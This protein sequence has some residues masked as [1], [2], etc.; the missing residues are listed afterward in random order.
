MA[1][2]IVRCVELVQVDGSA[3]SPV[4]RTSGI[5]NQEKQVT[6]IP[7]L[8]PDGTPGLPWTRGMTGSRTRVQ[9]LTTPRGRRLLAIRRLVFTTLKYEV[10]YF[11]HY[12]HGK[13]V[14]HYFIATY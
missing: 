6:G 4:T 2:P 14:V 1:E 9:R 13:H 11:F 12:I 8:Q 7:V 3:Y 10:N 5:K